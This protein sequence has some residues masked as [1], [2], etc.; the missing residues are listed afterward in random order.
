[1][2][3]VFGKK[4]A[5]KSAHRWWCCG[6]ETRLQEQRLHIAAVYLGDGKEAAFEVTKVVFLTA[7][8]SKSVP[9]AVDTSP[10]AR[11]DNGNCHHKFG[12]LMSIA[13]RRESQVDFKDTLQD[14]A[15]FECKH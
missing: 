11:S 6:G 15:E 13:K 3:V 1:M 12:H 14:A 9:T 4:S 5:R 10:L 2:I 7:S 8:N